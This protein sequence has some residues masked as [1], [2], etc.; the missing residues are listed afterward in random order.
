MV[1]DDFIHCDLHDDEAYCTLTCPP[2]CQ[3]NGFESTCSQSFLASHYPDFRY[4][5]ATNTG[6]A[7]ENFSLNHYLIHLN[8]SSCSISIIP[9]GIFLPNLQILN[10]RNNTLNS[11]D[12]TAF[13]T[14]QDL[15]QLILSWNPIYRIIASNSQNIFN[16][17]LQHVLL[18]GLQ[19]KVLDTKNLSVFS[20]LHN[21]DLSFGKFTE[22]KTL[23][24]LPNLKTIRMEGD[25]IENFDVDLYTGLNELKTLH[26]S[27][28]RLCC[29]QVLPPHLP[30]KSCSAEDYEISSCSDLLRSDFYRTFLFIFA[31]FAVAGKNIRYI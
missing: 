11:L 5:D 31:F 17:R 12:T 2:Q 10:L 20:N 14:F 18:Q 27:N 24:F 16:T 13:V 21:I 15:L 1:C 7:V 30:R 3:C 26:V 28:F 23:G 22:L 4:I 9:K 29:H 19:M 8:L 6:M 25:V